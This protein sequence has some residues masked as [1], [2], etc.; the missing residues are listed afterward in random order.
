MIYTL[1]LSVVM[2]KIRID[3][4][5]T[6]ATLELQPVFRNSYAYLLSNFVC[7][8]QLPVTVR[9]EHIFALSP[10]IFYK[11]IPVTKV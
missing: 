3:I 5:S 10:F 8:A 2:S 11:N 1:D 7:L 6:F 4:I 9:L